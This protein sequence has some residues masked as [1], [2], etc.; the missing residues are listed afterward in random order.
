MAWQ[1]LL[2]PVIHWMNTSPRFWCGWGMACLFVILAG[3][4]AYAVLSA[5]GM[6]ITA[7]HLLLLAGVLVGGLVYGLGVERLVQSPGWMLFYILIGWELLTFAGLFLRE[8]GY[9]TL[10]VRIITLGVMG[11]SGVVLVGYRFRR[12]WEELPPFR[13]FFIFLGLVTG[14]FFFY[15]VHF[16]DPGLA[17]R[18][19]IDYSREFFLN[20]VLI[21]IAMAFAYLGIRQADNW[22]LLFLR[23]N[24]GM[25]IYKSIEALCIIGGYPFQ[26]L[27]RNWDGFLRSSGF[28]IHPNHLAHNEAMWILYLVGLMSYYA[29]LPEGVPKLPRRLLWAALLLALCGLFLAMSKNSMALFTVVMGGYLS[30]LARY[31]NM[32]KPLVMTLCGL[33]AGIPLFLLLYQGL[34]GEIGRAHV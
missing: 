17:E 3:G 18:P 10:P 26:F 6:T 28:T 19:Y 27:S 7:T 20:L 12:L 8:N 9:P 29:L 32:R 11:V 21:L 33:C 34:M 2:N 5:L 15:N 31:F 13:Y 30:V 24:L 4:A 14:Y 1:P 22:R 16:A 23:I 25:L